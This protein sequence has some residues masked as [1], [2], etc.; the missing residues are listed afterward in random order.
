[1]R[2]TSGTRV[3]FGAAGIVLAATS[4]SSAPPDLYEWIALAPVVAVAEPQHDAGKFME[5][6]LANVLRGGLPEGSRVMIDVKRANRDREDGR[7]ALRLETDRRY[8]VLLRRDGSRVADDLPVFGLVRGIDGARELPAEGSAAVLDAIARFV[9][10]QDRKDEIAAWKSFREMLEETN[11]LFLE[12][13]LDLF[14][15]FRRGDLTLL[16]VL[17]PLLD[18]PRPDLRVMTARLVGQIVEHHTEDEIPADD[19]T[20]TALYGLAR[21]DP[22]AVVRVAATAAVGGIAGNGPEE[23]LEEIAHSDPE[24]SV[25]YEAEK[26]LYERRA[27]PRPEGRAPATREGVKS[28]EPSGPR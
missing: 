11:P 16:P 22:K 10:V 1:M 7:R 12:T 5:T 3:F 27:A 24:Q 8:L 9:Q 20:L 23:V 21:R 13:S 14:L 18:H 6:R 19:G 26:S 25:R 28:P 4:A 15:K 2:A 17:R